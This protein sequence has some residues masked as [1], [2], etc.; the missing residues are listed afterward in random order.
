MCQAAV[1]LRVEGSSL[2]IQKALGAWQGRGFT[3]EAIERRETPEFLG[4][5]GKH[6]LPVPSLSDRG[7]PSR[8]FRDHLFGTDKSGSKRRAS[9]GESTSGVSG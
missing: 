2:E 1:V 8:G 3:V 5:A 6:P 9:E 7:S 4:A